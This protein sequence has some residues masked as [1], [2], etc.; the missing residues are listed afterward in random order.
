[1]E[2]MTGANPVPHPESIAALIDRIVTSEWPAGKV[3]Q[4][5][6]FAR[7]GFD[8]VAGQ[9]S[10]RDASVV[11]GGL[12][13]PSALAITTAN[14]ASCKGNLFSINVF[15]DGRLS[16]E[17]SLVLS[18]YRYIHAVLRGKYGPPSD[19]SNHRS[20]SASS[21]WQIHGT[22]IEMYCHLDPSP[23]LQLGFSHTARNAEYEALL[24]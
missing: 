4:A 1:M 20:G 23:S 3:E 6:Y 21:K 24:T 22:T 15:L 11:A 8:Q 16:A 7:L 19:E 14:W 13:G 10:D 18:R 2:A 12:L 9:S 17:D 5:G